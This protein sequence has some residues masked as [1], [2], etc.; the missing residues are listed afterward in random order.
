[1]VALG[2]DHRCEGAAC[3]VLFDLPRKQLLKRFFSDEPWTDDD[4]D[5]LAELVGSGDGWWRHE[6][7]EDFVLEFGWRDG[8]FR[9]ELASRHGLGE[10]FAGVVVPE[11]TPNPR[12]I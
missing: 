5:A 9:M 8:A 2:Q 12:T 11:A 3:G 6:L 4:D 10:S 1:M 7:G